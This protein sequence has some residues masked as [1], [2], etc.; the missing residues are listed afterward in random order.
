[1]GSGGSS[2]YSDADGNFLFC[3][4]GHIVYDK[5]Y[6]IF[7][8]LDINNGGIPFLCS[9]PLL[10]TIVSQTSI[11]IPYPGNDSLYIIFHVNGTSDFSISPFYYTVIN[12]N[13]RGGLGE[14]EPGMKNIPLF[15]GREVDFKL[16]ATQHCNKRDIWVSGHFLNSDTYFSLLVTPAGVSTTPVTF[17]GNYVLANN[18]VTGFYNKF[19][20]LKIA[21]AGN[22]LAASFPLANFTEL[23]DFNN[24]TGMGTN[25]KKIFTNP[26]ATDTFYNITHPY[27]YG[28][29]C[30]EFAPSG[31]FIYIYSQFDHD[32]SNPV[33]QYFFQF[34]ASLPTQIAV[35]NSQYYYGYIEDR[36]GKSMQIAN[37]GK[38]YI[39]SSDDL[40]VIEKPELQGAASNFLGVVLPS[41]QTVLNLNLPNY[42]QSYFKYSLLITGACLS[43]TIQVAVQNP[44]GISSY[45]WNFGD[46]ASGASNTIT[47]PNPTHTYS[48]PGNYMLKGVLYNSNG[49]GADTVRKVVYAGQPSVNLGN[50]TAICQ[51]DSLTLRMRVPYGH[52]VWSN[53][54]TDTVLKV[55]VAGQYWVQ[56]NVG[57]C[58]IIDTI[59]ITQN[60]LPQFSLGNDTVVCNNNSYNLSPTPSIINAQFLWQNASTAPTNL[61]TNAG[62]YWL[63]ITNAIGCKKSDS[64][65]ISFKTL[66]NFN[67]GADASFCQGDSL[68]LSAN[69]LGATS[70]LWST[71]ASSQNIKVFSTNTYWCAVNKEGCIY[72]DSINIIAKPLPIVKL[73]NDTSLCEGI[74][75][76]LNATNINANYQWQNGNTTPT[77][78]VSNAGQYHVQVNLNNCIDR[79]S[80]V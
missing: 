50:D 52:N 73:G 76:L 40:A 80:V 25:L 22:K 6:K 15:G 18:L 30:L 69:V 31:K 72:A 48:A 71:G 44:V 49:C 58:S 36:I 79:K 77:F 67:L 42:V 54:S 4:N 24:V 38:L 7:P 53:G 34:D 11:C 65:N 26:P 33:D 17:S 43:Q 37:N 68:V 64:I 21:A 55:T 16:S 41:N 10:S 29:Q 57:G 60:S 8:S 35:Q 23:F 56:V 62:L 14:V 74:T 59:N 78:L 46:P 28:P 2:S 61:I 9:P 51:G 75:L 27:D 47:L 63:Q 70:Y 1:M 3:V 12:M 13:L 39:N 20:N 45:V 5:N 32:A 66:P 19:G